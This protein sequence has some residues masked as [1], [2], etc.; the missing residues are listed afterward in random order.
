[1]QIFNCEQGSDE[2]REARRGIATAS[3]FK[4]ILAKGQGKTRRTYLYQLAAERITG[5]PTA[6]FSNEHTQR[7]SYEEAEIRQL[8]ADSS[9][10]EIKEVGFIRLGHVGYS[11][12]GM[13]NDDGLIE[14]KSKLA[15]LQIAC[16]V[17]NKVPAEHIAQ[18]QGGLYITGRQWCDFISYCPGLPNFYKRVYRD[19]DYIAE[20]QDA[21]TQFEN[22]LDATVDLILSFNSSVAEWQ[23]ETLAEE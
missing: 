22:D 15:H 10:Y 9:G 17:E 8:Y 21:L 2:W 13:V 6:S 11:P 4:D 23:Q 14:I 1:M 7:G 19:D 5:L 18:I 16:I 20:L 12:D 3:K